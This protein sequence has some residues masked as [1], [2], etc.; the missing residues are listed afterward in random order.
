[1]I[2]PPNVMEASELMERGAANG[3]RRAR[4]GVTSPP[5]ASSRNELTRGPPYATMTAG[6]RGSGLAGLG[7]SPSDGVAA[8][9]TDSAVDLGNKV[10]LVRTQLSDGLLHLD[11]FVCALDALT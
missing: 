8:I 5:N 10:E 4:A 2:V 9:V 3:S 6:L 11:P 7:A 1:M